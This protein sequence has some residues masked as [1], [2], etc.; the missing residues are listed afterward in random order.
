MKKTLST[1]ALV[2]VFGFSIAFAQESASSLKNN[3]KQI[4][5]LFKAIALSVS[6][7]SKNADNID[8]TK[9]LILLFKNTLTLIPDS[10]SQLPETQRADSITQFQ[11]LINDELTNTNLLQVALIANDNATAAGIVQ[12]M[13]VTKKEGHT[14]FDP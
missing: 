14:R 8:K 7:P 2:L 1:F 9:Q 12:K 11:N 5:P 6:D 13:T 4:G 3:M 10:V